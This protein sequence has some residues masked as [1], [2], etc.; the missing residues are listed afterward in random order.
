MVLTHTDIVQYIDVSCVRTDVTYEE[1]TQVAAA[2]KKYNF[3]CAFA[4][5]CFTEKLRDLLKGSSV[6]LGGAVGFPSGA[7]T[8][9]QKVGCAQYLKA[10]GCDE[11]DMVI[12]VGALKSEDDAYVHNDIRKVVEAV[13]PIPVKSI[14]ECAY[15]SDEEI[16]RA[17]NIAVEAGVS[18]VKSG[19]GW[20]AKPTTVDMIRLMKKSVGEK[21]LIKAAGGVRSLAVLEEM[22]AVG[23]RRFGISLSSALNILREAYQRDGVVFT[24]GNAD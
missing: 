5:P 15:L 23:C 4:M 19:T 8:T 7:D 14:L 20:A 2:A 17:C 21:V 24:W 6:R 13:Y 12:N 11:V 9:D 10:V 1:V 18:F 16:I 3:I 22:Y